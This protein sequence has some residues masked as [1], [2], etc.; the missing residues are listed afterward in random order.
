M[1]IIDIVFV[2]SCNCKNKA[3]S[4]TFSLRLKNQI[5][6]SKKDW[7]N[8]NTVSLNRKVEDQKF[9]ALLVLINKLMSLPIKPHKKTH[10]KSLVI[11]LLPFLFCFWH[12]PSLVVSKTKLG[13]ALYFGHN[14]CRSS[15]E[16]WDYTFFKPLQNF[17]LIILF[18]NQYYT[19]LLLISSETKRTCVLVFS[20]CKGNNCLNTQQIKLFQFEM[21][22][23]IFLNC[24]N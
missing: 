19:N 18:C 2:S 1:Y 8:P 23:T 16:Y 15:K 4:L 6:N 9:S 12:L 5:H 10:L 3:L 21:S 13:L 7:F 24:D 17:I 20:T 14:I 22:I 11:G